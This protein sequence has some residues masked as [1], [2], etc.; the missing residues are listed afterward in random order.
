METFGAPDPSTSHTNAGLLVNIV[1]K[2]RR[3]NA[4]GVEEEF[5][6]NH[7]DVISCTTCHI[8]KRYAAAR[9]IDFSTGSQFFNFV[10]NPLDQASGPET[11]DLAYSWK[12]TTP[13][14][15]LPNGTPNPLWRRLI[16]PFN[17]VT[18]IYWNN[19]GTKDANGDGFTTGMSNNGAIVVGD[20]FFQRNVKGNFAYS[21]NSENNRIPVGLLNSAVFDTQS[22]KNGDDAIIFTRP[23]EIE[24][25]KSLVTSKDPGYVPQLVLE[26]EPYLVMHN[27]LSPTIFA[28]GKTST[29]TTGKKVYGCSD[30][31]GAA[32]GIYNGQINMIGKEKHPD[33]SQTAVSI[34][35]NNTSDVLTKALYWDKNGTKQSVS[36]SNLTVSPKTTRNPSRWEFLG[37]DTTRVTALNTILPPAA[38]GIGID[39]KAVI[40]PI[41]DAD[42]TQT[43][44]QVITGVPV[45]VSCP[46]GEFIDAN[47]NGKYDAGE[48]LVGTVTYAWTTSDPGATII[49]GSTQNATITFATTGT[50][51]ITLTVK[52]EESKVSSSYVTVYAV[53]PPIAIGWTHTANPATGTATITNIPNTTMYVKIYW[54]D[55]ALTTQTITVGNTTTSATHAYATTTSKIIQ[56]YCYNTAQKQIGYMQQTIT[57]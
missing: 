25:Y 54:G 36:F 11:V 26:S 46:P 3:I 57:P 15:L 32:G 38:Y 30:C 48:T 21:V 6:G 5:I 24:A 52:D 43:G 2:A 51:T 42:T 4:Q 31:H 49:N 16:Y 41:A 40:N 13:V 29:D 45:S 8:Q 9:S 44:I 56:V 34:S 17:Y 22:M 50:K 23:S 47:N 12:E 1:T 7:L 14:K 20:P 19:I 55:G 35:W 10:G 39:P 53:V 33:N 37:Y 28:P 18:G 27:V